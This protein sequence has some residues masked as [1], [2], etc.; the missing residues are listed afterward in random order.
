MGSMMIEGCGDACVPMGLIWSVSAAVAGG[1]GE[2]GSADWA[3][4][5]VPG[6]VVINATGPACVKMIGPQPCVNIE[7][8]HK[9][10]IAAFFM[11]HPQTNRKK[12]LS[13]Q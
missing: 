4:V 1:E 13:R 10:A 6:V 9:S 7:K 3:G 5:A 2:A 11:F 8:A 12:T